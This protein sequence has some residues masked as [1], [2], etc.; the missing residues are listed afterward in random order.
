MS[1]FRGPSIYPSLQK[2]AERQSFQPA[3]SV[4]LKRYL[5]NRRLQ[6]IEHIPR[7]SFSRPLARQK[8]VKYTHIPKK[9]WNFLCETFG[10]SMSTSATTMSSS[11]DYAFPQT[12]LKQQL[13][14][15]SRQPLVLVACGSFSPITYL[16]LRM[17]EMAS[18]YVRLNTNFELVGC[19]LSPVADAYKKK[20][21]APAPN[22]YVRL[23][24][25]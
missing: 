24:P 22:R 13:K 17:F 7:S 14:D 18:D 21:L 15:L 11:Q 8:R 25:G 3:L 20:G 5:L 4:Y 9:L 19:Y 6:W 12:K 10:T 1:C 23:L 2:V 16:H